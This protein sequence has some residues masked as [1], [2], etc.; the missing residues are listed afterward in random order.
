VQT[1]HHPAAPILFDSV[2]E[3]WQSAS[4][5]HIGPV[6]HEVDPQEVSKFSGSLLGLTP[7]GWMRAWDAEGH[8]RPQAWDSAELLGPRAGAVVI[9]REDVGGDEEAIETLAHHTRVLAVTEGPAGSV[10]YWNGDRRRFRAPEVLEVM[11]PYFHGFRIVLQVIVPVGEPEA[12]LVGLRDHLAGVLE[13][14]SGAE[15]EQRGHAVP[16]HPHDLGSEFRL[17]LQIAN[18]LKLRLY[19]GQSLAID[20]LL[21]HT[22]GIVITDLLGNRVAA[23]GRPRRVFQNLL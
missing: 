23:G 6:V 14:L 8:V 4:I 16:M 17:V 20:G 19:G 11:L 7:Q 2:P 9:S 18:P 21:I 15:L 22:G 1:V 13:V 5:V 10:L 3:T 12:A